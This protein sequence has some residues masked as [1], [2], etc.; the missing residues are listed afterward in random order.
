MLLA[1]GLARV[2]DRAM[3]H[4]MTDNEQEA[5]RIDVE[6][7]P[8]VDESRTSELS[9]WIAF[10]MDNLIRVPGTNFRVG[11]DPLIGLLPGLGDS[12]TAL[13]SAGILLQAATQGVPKIVLTRMAL[14]VLINS[15]FGAVPV[16]GD[17][18]SIWF[19]SNARNHQLLVRHSL[20]QKHSTRSDWAFVIGLL[21]VLAACV[22]ASVAISVWLIVRLYQLFSSMN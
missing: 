6:V 18:F 11:L 1:L 14:N 15:A 10:V 13:V 4:S 20:G 9:R 17:A 22:V 7:M 12:G 16:V 19:K 21:T 8:S 3:L 5:R 2:E